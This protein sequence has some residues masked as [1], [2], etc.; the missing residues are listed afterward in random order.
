MHEPKVMG[1]TFLEV[2]LNVLKSSSIK[3]RA[4]VN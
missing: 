4:V 2:E 3:K 1:S